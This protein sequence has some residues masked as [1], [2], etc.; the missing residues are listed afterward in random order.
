M[1]RKIGA[2]GGGGGEGQDGGRMDSSANIIMICR[3]VL[4]LVCSFISILS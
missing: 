1:P 4:H 2:G 3:F